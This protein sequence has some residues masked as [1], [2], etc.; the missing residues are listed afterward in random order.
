MKVLINL[1][2]KFENHNKILF[3]LCHCHSNPGIIDVISPDQ[4]ILK[5]LMRNTP[6]FL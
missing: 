2:L 4:P 3:Y 5:Q 1:N 6:K